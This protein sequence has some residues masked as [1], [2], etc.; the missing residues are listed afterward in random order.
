MKDKKIHI[1]EPLIINILRLIAKI[2]VRLFLGYKIKNKYKAKK[3]EKVIVLSNHQTDYDPI[4]VRLSIN[5]YLYTLSTD[6]IFSNKI[7]AK[8]LL[9]LGAIPKRKGTYDVKAT[10]KMV[11]ISNKGGSL[12]I[13]PE[14]NRSYAEFQFYIADNIVKLIKLTQPTLILFNIHGGFASFPR[15]SNRRRKGP[16]Y[17]EIK[18]VMP[19]EEYK[20]LSNEELL[21]IIKENI[22]IFDSDSH[23]LYKSSKKAEQLERMFF[24][25][26]KCQ[27]TQTLNSKGNVLR[28]NNCSLEVNYQEDLTLKSSD[29]T[30]R[31]TRL[32]DWYDYQRKFL[33]EC[34]IKENEPIFI[35]EDV[36]LTLANPFKKREILAR[37]KLVLTS[38]TI[39]VDKMSFDIKNISISS[40]VSGRNL[41]FTIKEN[42]Y[43]IRGNVKFNALKYVMIFHR[44]ETLMK[45]NNID[46]YYTLKGDLNR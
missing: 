27:S 43:E 46:N 10:M 24:V 3:N 32:V 18:K 40:P 15:F 2:Y 4:L 12:L 6:S 36:I 7:I 5:R 37:G 33:L 22:K 30:F 39:S 23:Q 26:P 25:C 16:F 11:K 21:N 9:G 8:I 28:C 20:N 13:F 31:F 34:D 19:Y 35:D 45:Q 41:E 44:L 1:K 17:G 42:N 14:G 29:P 38:T